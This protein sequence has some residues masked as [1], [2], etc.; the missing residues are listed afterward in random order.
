[1]RGI[2][3]PP[4]V[5]SPTTPPAPAMTRHRLGPLL[6]E[7]RV[8]VL[9]DRLPARPRP[10]PH[11]RPGVS[12]EGP[13]RDAGDEGGHRDPLQHE[14]GPGRSGKSDR[15]VRGRCSVAVTDAPWAGRAGA[16]PRS[17]MRSTSS[18]SGAGAPPCADLK[19]R[20]HALRARARYPAR[21]SLGRVGRLP[22]VA[23]PPV[24]LLFPL[25]PFPLCSLGPLWV[26]ESVNAAET[27]PAARWS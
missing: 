23:F 24:Q 18:V 19:E 5:R 12:A 10:A 20:A 6:L 8:P 4:Y 26:P 22:L 13:A 7:R 15:L 25:C 2:A 9:R 17:A 21:P 3:N 16:C 1:M 14:R 27:A 11:L